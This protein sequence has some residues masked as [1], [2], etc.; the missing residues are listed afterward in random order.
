M[1][2]DRTIGNIFPKIPVIESKRL[3]IALA[4]LGA[5]AIL[6]WLVNG[7]VIARTEVFIRRV[8]DVPAAMPSYSPLL[9]DPLIERLASGAQISADGLTLVYSAEGIE[10]RQPCQ[11]RVVIE[12]LASEEMEIASLGIFETPADA[13]AVH[14][15]IS[16][17][18]RLVV[19][20]SPATN[21]V[22]RDT[23]VAS[24]IFLYERNTGKNRRVSLGVDGAQADGDSYEPAISADGHYVTFV[25]YAENLVEGDTNRSADVFLAD[26]EKS[27]IRRLSVNAFGGQANRDIHNPVISADGKIVAFSS[28]ADNLVA[29]DANASEDVFVVSVETGEIS[30]LSAAKDGSQADGDSFDPALAADG[31]LLAFASYASNL[32]D[33]KNGAVNV[34]LYDALTHSTRCVSCEAMQRDG[35]Q[36]AWKPRFAPDGRLLLFEMYIP[37]NASQAQNLWQSYAYDCE[38][39]QVYRLAVGE[40]GGPPQD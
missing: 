18:G 38:H 19:Y 33:E 29:A 37:V 30:L 4:S 26:L 10:C 31:R 8:F 16:G 20:S 17:D 24:D 2:L 12:D 1:N 39:D 36:A 13:E 25:S 28:A 5:L 3:I 32:T 14:P 15:S 34:F 9:S 6:I 35:S 23:N 11:A 27:T 40:A 21:L 22:S 7:A